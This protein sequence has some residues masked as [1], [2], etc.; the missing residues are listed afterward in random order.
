M[1]SKT[2]YLISDEQITQL[3][4]AN[5][6]DK[7]RV[8]KIEELK[9]GMF[10][11]AYRVERLSEADS[12]ILKVSVRP[13]T[14]VLSYEKDLMPVE[15]EVYRLI[16]E[17]TSIPVPKILCADFSKSLLDSNYF[18]M[19]ALQGEAM[20][21]IQSK[22]SKDNIEAIKKEL[23]SYFGQIHQITGPHFGY[24]SQ[25]PL[26]QFTTWKQ[27]FLSMTGDILR[28][29]REHRVRLPYERVE[30]VLQK[31]SG[32][33]D[34]VQEP[35]LVDYD[36]WTGNIFLVNNG[37]GYQI[38]AIIDFERA[39]WGDAYADFSCIF[40]L[41]E[42][43]WREP[44]FWS[45]YLSASASQ[46]SITRE[47]ETRI[48]LYSLYLWMIMTVEVFRYHFPEKLFQEVFSRNNLMKTLKELEAL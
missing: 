39:F 19:S 16:S 14:T 15:V 4:K 36:L 32:L 9:G 45:S 35:V 5:F 38:E 17:Q 25:D 48:N 6:G 13:G 11:S 41:S 10:N 22:L 27:A 12:V 44:V 2:K 47:D 29:G 28:D 43:I 20:N 18:F 46:K 3:V 37:S 26:R 7:T 23:G 21:T 1:K 24:F 31:H 42:K 33:L 30:K 34:A 8:G 40:M